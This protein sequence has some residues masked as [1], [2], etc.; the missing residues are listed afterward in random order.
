M[1]GSGSSTA[2]QSDTTSAS[3][4]VSERV[5]CPLCSLVD[6]DRCGDGAAGGAAN[7][8]IGVARSG[9]MG[10]G[11]AGGAAAAI[12]KLFSCWT[13]QETSV[14]FSKE[15]VFSTRGPVAFSIKL[16][17]NRKGAEGAAPRASQQGQTRTG[18]KEHKFVHSGSE[19]TRPI[20]CKW[21]LST[22]LQCG[23]KCPH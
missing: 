21:T 11:S 5:L 18:L 16:W 14:A 20:Q 10:G 4:A 8:V 17:H 6:D 22:E 3:T 19:G 12:A 23:A 2:P 9:R 13:R 15:H 1:K 7:E